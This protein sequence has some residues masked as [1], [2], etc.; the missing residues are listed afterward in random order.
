MAQY[1]NEAF[2]KAITQSFLEAWWQVKDSKCSFS[3]VFGVTHNAIF[4]QFGLQRSNVDWTGKTVAVDYMPKYS[5]EYTRYEFPLPDGFHDRKDR[6]L[7][8]YEHVGVLD[9]NAGFANDK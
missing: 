3:S 8:M 1:R 9:D 2:E 7:G 4:V 6:V 5:L